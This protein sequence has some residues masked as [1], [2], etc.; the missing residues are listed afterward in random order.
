[1][2]VLSLLA[3]RA[4]VTADA[5]Q[6]FVSGN[7]VSIGKLAVWEPFSREHIVAYLAL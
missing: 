3:Y 2:N 5:A 6:E 4:S 1:M 7:S